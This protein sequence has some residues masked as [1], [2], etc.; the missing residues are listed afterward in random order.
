MS[1]K[2]TETLVRNILN[3]R[4]ELPKTL[5]NHSKKSLLNWLGVAIGASHHPSIDMVLEVIKDVGSR[6]EVSIFGRSERVDILWGS[7]INGMSSHVFDFD[8]T[9]LDSIHHP[10]GP[11]APVVF[12][13]GEK[14]C[15][16]GDKL[17]HAFIIG[18]EVELRISNAIYPHHYDLGWHITSTAGVFGAA[19]AAGLLLNLTEEQ[20]IYALGIA[21]TQS[22][23]LR[24]MFGT[25]TKSFHPGKAAQNGL[26]AALLAKKG[27][28]SSKH[29][30]EAKRGFANVLSPEHDLRKVNLAWG[31]NWE[32]LKN[33]FKPYAC[34]IVLHPAIDACIELRKY[35]TPVDVQEVQ[36]EVNPYVLELT[37]K[38]EPK[39]GLEG[40][41]SIYHSAA[42]A[43]IEG[44]ASQEQYSDE[45]V[46]E[47]AEFR[48]KI[49]IFSDPTL[50]EDQAVA[51]LIL[52]NG[53]KIEFKVEHATG[54]LS[55]PMTSEALVKKFMKLVSPIIG[56]SNIKQLTNQILT[57]EKL[58]NL[59]EVITYCK[60]NI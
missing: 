10:S 26:L 52:L 49:K 45:R 53:E 56:T 43:F 4:V 3:T 22:S 23:G 47:T 35:A 28:T 31:E 16:S 32:L 21:G 59:A 6:P 25:M 50:R 29:V 48:K 8:D 33:T 15:F 44:D 58:P 1:K 7:L 19:A 9:H 39:N 12:A 60:S 36:I 51:K 24:E 13:L 17:L 57:I 42:I 30:L 2:V 38:Q 40:K 34:G 55:N 18:R 37:G 5:I 46:L 20:M 14:Y 27:F 54:C 11:V 41:F